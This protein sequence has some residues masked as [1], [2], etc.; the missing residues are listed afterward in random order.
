M[1]DEEA[2]IRE[3]HLAYRHV[4]ENHTYRHR[5]DEVFR[6]VGLESLVTKRPSVSVLMPTMRPE[7]VVQCLDN[8][9]KQTYPEKELILILNNAAFDLES[10]REQTED[11]PNVQVL[12]VDGPTSLGDCLNRGISA[13]S[14]DYVAKMDDDDCYG[15]RYLSDSVLAASF[16][17]AEVTG[18]GS[19]FMYFEDTDTTALAEVAREHTFTHFVTG[20]TMFIRSDVA[21]RFPF[22]A[23][24]LR[25]DTNFL[26]AVA[27]AGCRIYAA[28]RF[29]FIRVRTERLSNHADPTPDMEF[30]RRCRAKTPGL[31][32]DRVMI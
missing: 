29:N 13:S 23:I 28:D 20:G 16:S 10:I 9:Q 26:H 8:F 2:R 11:I 17:D 18:K 31:D 22:D 3:G 21:R 25:E 30:L 6:R 24:S 12:H 27:Q 5:M 19:F 1:G 7:N 15:E 4:H 14:G 32:L